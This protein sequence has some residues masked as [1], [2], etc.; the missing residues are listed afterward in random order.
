[1]LKWGGSTVLHL[2][3][4]CGHQAGKGSPGLMRHLTSYESQWEVPGVLAVLGEPAPP[5]LTGLGVGSAMV[6]QVTGGYCAKYVC[7]CHKR[8]MSRGMCQICLGFR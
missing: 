3:A 7:T 1:M 6:L 5:V 2:P 8:R 4:H